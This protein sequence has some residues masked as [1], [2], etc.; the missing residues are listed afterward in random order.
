MLNNRRKKNKMANT[1]AISGVDS[2]LLYGAESTYNTAVTAD[3][4]FGL[5][6]SFSPRTNNSNNYTRG[7]VGTTT[8]G[9]NVAKILPGKIENEIGVEL[10]VTHWDWLEYVLGSVT[11]SGPYTY[12][13]ANNPGSLTIGRQIVN[14][15]S[16]ATDRDEQWTGA[17]IDSCTIKASVGEP[18]SVSLTLKASGHLYDTTVQTAQALPSVEVFNFSGGTIEL[19]DATPL[20]NIIDSV[21]IS[22][23]NNYDI[24]YGLGDRR[25][26][27]AK[28][29]GRD[30]KIKFT[31]KYLD[32]NLLGALLGA[33][34]PT[35]TTDPTEYASMA[36]KFSLGGKSCDFVFSTVTFDSLSGKEDVTEIIGEDIE[37]TAISCEVTDDRSA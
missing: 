12:S 5:V 32:N 20:T 26:Q 36:I 24:L 1:E 21:E 34:E 2:Y 14:P 31:V 13:E 18:V 37:A 33:A 29:K 28:A 16:S 17:V 19:P 22:I 15:G 7:F 10:D 11:G 6:K 23:S 30:Y 27:N 8:G 3:T 9:R 35:A 4:H 25:G